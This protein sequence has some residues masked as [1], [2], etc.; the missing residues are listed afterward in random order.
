MQIDRK[1]LYGILAMSRDRIRTLGFQYSKTADRL[2][3]L[4]AQ[5]KTV[6]DED[7]QKAQVDA[8]GY[9]K[10]LQLCRDLCAALAAG[11]KIRIVEDNHPTGD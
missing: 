9:I 7:I 8:E 6:R 1:T 4:K 10:Y 2:R 5:G 11:E 3:D